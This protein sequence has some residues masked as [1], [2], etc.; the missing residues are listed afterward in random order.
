[1]GGL[2]SFGWMSLLFVGN[3][4]N[5]LSPILVGS[6]LG[7]VSSLPIFVAWTLRPFFKFLNHLL[8]VN[9]AV[10]CS[11]KSSIYTWTKLISLWSP[12]CQSKKL[13]S[14]MTLQV[15]KRAFSTSPSRL[16]LCTPS[17]G[18]ATQAQGPGHLLKINHWWPTKSF[19]KCQRED[20]PK[21]PLV[22]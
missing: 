6:P 19:K 12:L 20:S 10:S 5:W 13:A 17:Q 2:T 4:H 11:R 8:L 3:F 7:I 1:M 22:N 14:W 18:L 16:A 15:Q 21:Y 9:M